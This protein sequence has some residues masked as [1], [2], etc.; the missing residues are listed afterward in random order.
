MLEEDEVLPEIPE[1]FLPI[2]HVFTCRVQKNYNIKI[3]ETDTPFY[4]PGDFIYV[5]TERQLAAVLHE[6]KLNDE[7]KA[8]LEAQKMKI[9][10]KKDTKM[11]NDNSH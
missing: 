11:D 10:R 8:R 6:I 2:K 9:F 5:S 1:E 7:K 4:H 3:P